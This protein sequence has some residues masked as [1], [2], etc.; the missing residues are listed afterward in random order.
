MVFG[1]GADVIGNGVELRDAHTKGKGT[2]FFL[3]V[4]R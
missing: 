2:V 1:L 4:R 3:L